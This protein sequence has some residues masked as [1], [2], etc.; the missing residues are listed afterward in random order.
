MEEFTRCR[1]CESVLPRQSGKG[2]TRLYC[3]NRCRSLFYNANERNSYI[4]KS[5]RRP[6]GGNT[7]CEVDGCDGRAI[8]LGLCGMHYARKNYNPAA[9]SDSC[10]VIECESG[11][12]CRG[13]CRLHYERLIRN[14]DVGPVRRKK[15]RDGQGRSVVR[16]YIRLTTPDGRRMDEHRFVMEQ[17]LGRVLAPHE[18]VHHVNGIRDDNRPENLEL[19]VKAQPCGQ[20]PS[21]LVEWVVAEYPELVEAVLASRLQLRLAV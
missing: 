13:Y 7:T 21:D 5:N 6:P 8:A 14:G 12:W 19:W 10:N 11:R 18:N 1:Q 9:K 2:R 15:A 4:P 17:V 20:R 16:G 3:N